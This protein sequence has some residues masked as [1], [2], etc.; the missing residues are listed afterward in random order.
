[1]ICE[2]KK[3][4]DQEGG[5]VNDLRMG[6]HLPPFNTVDH[7]HLHLISPASSMNI[8]HNVMFKPNTWWFS[9]VNIRKHI[10]FHFKILCLLGRPNSRKIKPCD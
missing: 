4:I 2:G 7:L 5:D 8:L 9:T 1:M 10:I 3:V 6:F